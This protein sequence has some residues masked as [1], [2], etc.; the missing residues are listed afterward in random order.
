MFLNIKKLKALI[1]D[2]PDEMQVAVPG[3]DHSYNQCR[4]RITHV[5][6]DEGHGKYFEYAGDHNLSPTEVKT[7]IFLISDE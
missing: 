4:G 3:F 7:Q 2:L 5:A 6:W 1:A